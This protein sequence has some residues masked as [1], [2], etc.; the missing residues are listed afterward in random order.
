MT[1]LMK[2]LWN[3]ESG[4]T[5]VEYAMIVGLIIAVVVAAMT[6]FK[7]G[8]STLFTKVSTKAGTAVDTGI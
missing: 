3:D 1:A 7:G 8:I 2:N 6:T 5:L 4:A